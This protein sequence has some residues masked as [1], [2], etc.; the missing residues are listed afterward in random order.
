[1]IDEPFVA[2]VRRDERSGHRAV[3]EY[4]YEP[5]LTGHGPGHIRELHFRRRFP[6]RRALLLG[7]Y[8]LAIA[9]AELLMAEDN[10]KVGAGLLVL[11]VGV[12]L[13]L[14]SLTTFSFDVGNR[15]TSPYLIEPVRVETE[16][17]E[18][19]AQSRDASIE[20]TML[21]TWL[22]RATQ[23][24]QANH[25]EADR[26]ARR[27]WT[28]NAT[29]A[30]SATLAAASSAFLAATSSGRV[31]AASVAAASS[32]IAAAI[33]LA[34]PLGRYDERSVQRRQTA[35]AWASIES[36]IRELSLPARA[37]GVSAEEIADLARQ[38]DEL[39]NSEC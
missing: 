34:R 4:W 5:P 32:G 36:R 12:F 10:S 35:T 38:I 25:A 16:E 18:S 21:A 19:P 20:R 33:A 11:V 30:G 28:L 17:A 22:E 31:A 39:T 8:L 26:L 27:G 15:A 6:W 14:A 24:A 1:M 2:E 29:L 9:G 3:V 13:A 23:T 37:R 7:L